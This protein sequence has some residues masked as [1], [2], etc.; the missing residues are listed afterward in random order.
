[1]VIQFGRRSA[2][3]L[4]FSA[5]S[6]HRALSGQLEMALAVETNLPER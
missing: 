6:E 1:M 2:E 5:E 4:H 3:F